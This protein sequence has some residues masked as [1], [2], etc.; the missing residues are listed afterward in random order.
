MSKIY[1]KENYYW[2]TIEKDDNLQLS[3]N[4]VH[5]C[6]PHPC[7]ITPFL[8]FMSLDWKR[9][10]VVILEKRGYYF[11]NF[12]F[13]LFSIKT[14]KG[15]TDGINRSYTLLTIFGLRWYYLILSNRLTRRRFPNQTIDKSV[16]T[17][18]LM[19]LMA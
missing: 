6:L 13:A 9:R 12:L 1:F 4:S 3:V 14:K 7:L 8:S 16:I 11:C 18:T 2:N 10:E 5:P 17:Q 15:K 19:G